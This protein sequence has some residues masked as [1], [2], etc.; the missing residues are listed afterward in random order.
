MW[1]RQENQLVKPLGVRVMEGTF[2]EATN[3][4]VLVS[5]VS[6]AA[7]HE[8]R[9]VFL[10]PTVGAEG[11]RAWAAFTRGCAVSRA[12]GAPCPAPL[13]RSLPCIAAPRLTR[14][15]LGRRLLGRRLLR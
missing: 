5:V 10:A 12:A 7:G 13:P 1:R 9:D 11:W 14:R 8:E 3:P 6:G 2:P 4:R 15:L